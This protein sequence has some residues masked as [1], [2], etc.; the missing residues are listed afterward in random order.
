[1]NADDLFAREDRTG[2]AQAEEAAMYMTREDGLF[3]EVA[4]NDAGGARLD[5]CQFRQLVCLLWDDDIDRE[6]LGQGVSDGYGVIQRACDFE[7]VP[8]NACEGL[9]EEAAVDAPMS[10]GGHGA[11]K[12]LW[13]MLTF[14]AKVAARWHHAKSANLLRFERNRRGRRQR[15]VAGTPCD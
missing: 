10:P 14:S 8:L 6:I 15:I 13:R 11:D 1:M 2:V 12:S 5:G 4:A 3:P 7:S 9:R